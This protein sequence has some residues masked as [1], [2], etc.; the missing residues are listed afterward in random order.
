MG[1]SAK[2]RGRRDSSGLLG[3]VSKLTFK[4]NLKINMGETD[5][6]RA[7]EKGIQGDKMA[8]ARHREVNRTRG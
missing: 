5:C 4:L 2:C 8:P 6:C 7:K 3:K 1:V